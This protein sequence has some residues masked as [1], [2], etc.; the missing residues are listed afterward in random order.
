MGKYG[1]NPAN[2]AVIMGTTQ[3]YDLLNDAEFGDVQEVGA[4]S[5]K[6]NGSLGSVYGM[7]IIVSEHIGSAAAG[8]TAFTIVNKDN[9]VIPRLAGVNIESDYSVANQRTDI[10][11]SQSLGFN[12]ISAGTDAPHGH[13]SVCALYVA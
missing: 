1:M 5:T 11:A 12:A 13:P 2:L 6:V 9:Y 7:D 4:M 10:V 3:Y 8:K